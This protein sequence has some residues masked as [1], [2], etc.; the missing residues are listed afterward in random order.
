VGRIPILFW[1]IGWTA[2]PQSQQINNPGSERTITGLKK[3]RKGS[4][5]APAKDREVTFPDSNTSKVL[6]NGMSDNGMKV[7]KYRSLSE[8]SKYTTAPS[9]S[10]MSSA[11]IY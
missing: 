3:H 2:E 1:Q 9:Y 6:Q 10:Q 5:V 8:S 4:F 7:K 11:I